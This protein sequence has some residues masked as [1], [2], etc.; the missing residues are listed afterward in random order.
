MDLNVFNCGR[1]G[2]PLSL[3]IEDIDQAGCAQAVLPVILNTRKEA[4]LRECE[5]T[6]G[7]WI[8]SFHDEFCA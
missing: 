2:H 8:L 6:L 5:I 4:S 7:Y 1:E 3:Q